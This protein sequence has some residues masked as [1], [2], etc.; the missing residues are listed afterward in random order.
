MSV[1]SQAYGA[2]GFGR[3]F[4]D[5]SR[6]VMVDSSTTPD[7]PLPVVGWIVATD[8]PCKGTELRLHAGM[9]LI[10]RGP[11]NDVCMRWDETVSVRNN[12]AIAYNA[13]E[14]R[15]F[16][17]HVTGHGPTRLNGREVLRGQCELQALDRLVIGE[18]SFV[19]VPL[20]GPGF[21]WEDETSPHDA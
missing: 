18:T 7:A 9:N 10:G 14:R 1:R 8:G 11:E 20:C 2:Q 17:S 15:F 21:C 3:G 4:A 19:F 6:T 5:Q 12:S 16:L 13:D